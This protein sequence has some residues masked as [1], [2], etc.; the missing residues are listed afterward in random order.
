MR[1]AESVCIVAAISGPVSYRASVVGGRGK[2]KKSRG[3][4]NSGGW[5]VGGS[6][7]ATAGTEREERVER[8]NGKGPA[9]VVSTLYSLL[10]TLST[11][12]F[13][14]LAVL[15]LAKSARDE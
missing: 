15:R 8:R 12:P 5:V 4:A 1:Y 14:S 3:T 10:S 2:V 6:G 13:H 7:T 11:L 9:P